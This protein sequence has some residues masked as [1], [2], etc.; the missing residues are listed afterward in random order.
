MKPFFE[1]IL[2]IIHGLDVVLRPIDGILFA[3]VD[4]IRKETLIYH[5]SQK[6]TWI[7]C[8]IYG[9]GSI[10][11][12]ENSS[13]FIYSIIVGY[14][15]LAFVIT[16]VA[17]IWFCKAVSSITF[18]K[19]LNI[20]PPAQLVKHILKFLLLYAVAQL[21]FSAIVPG[22][23]LSRISAAITYLVLAPL[24]LGA[25]CAYCF[26][27]VFVTSMRLYFTVKES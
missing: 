16:I 1:S 4:A 3:Q 8:I 9:I 24:F 27:E 20:D 6:W 10:I 14:S 23:D 11:I 22:L 19:S 2:K 12:N 25:I 17:L 15:A 18:F 5:Y 21:V 7:A 13:D 26:A